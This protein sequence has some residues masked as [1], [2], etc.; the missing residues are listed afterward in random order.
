[1]EDQSRLES[2]CMLFG[3][4]LVLFELNKDSP[5]FAIRV[6]AQRFSPDMF[7]AN[8]FAD[9]LKTVQ[10]VDLQGTV[11]L[12]LIPFAEISRTLEKSFDAD[13]QKWV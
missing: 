5:R 6:R 7:Y 2:L 9:R 13:R 8:E 3:I 12:R 10:F 4:G 11:P 1:M